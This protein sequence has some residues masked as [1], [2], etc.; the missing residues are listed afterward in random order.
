MVD[1]HIQEIWKPRLGWPSQG[2]EEKL[3]FGLKQLGQG[4]GEELMRWEDVSPQ[5]LPW[6]REGIY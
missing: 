1:G 3:G 2:H 4:L 5:V 6:Q